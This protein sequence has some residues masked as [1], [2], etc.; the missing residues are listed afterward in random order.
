MYYTH[1]YFWQSGARRCRKSWGWWPCKPD[2]S[3]YNQYH[4]GS[5]LERSSSMNLFV[6]LLVTITHSQTDVNCLSFLLFF[7]SNSTL[8]LY[9]SVDLI[10]LISFGHLTVMLSS[11]VKKCCCIKVKFSLNI[12]VRLTLSLYVISFT[13]MD[14]LSLSDIRYY[15]GFHR[16][17]FKD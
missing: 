13:P 6:F 3:I 14:C 10:Q 5:F 16:I 4:N 9:N 7:A 11:Y 15:E 2:Y 17:L 12:T 8:K 1:R